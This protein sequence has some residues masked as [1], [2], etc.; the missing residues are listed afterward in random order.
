MYLNSRTDGWSDIPGMVSLCSAHQ[1]ASNDIHFDLKGALRSRDLRSSLDLDLDLI[2]S[3]YTYFDVYQ[4]GD[5]DGANIFTL[6]RLVQ[7]SLAKN[8]LVLKCRYFYFLDPCDVI[9]D[10]T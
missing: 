9:F 7:K 10:L 3:S 4:R 6:A 8:S 1:G 2:R 5:L